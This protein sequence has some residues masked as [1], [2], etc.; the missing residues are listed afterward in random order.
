MKK[1][2]IFVFLSRMS[3]AVNLLPY[4]SVLRTN[5]YICRYI[6]IY[7]LIHI[8]IDILIRNNH[9]QRFRPPTDSPL[10]HYYNSNERFVNLLAIPYAIATSVALSLH[11]N[12]AEDRASEES[13]ILWRFAAHL[14]FCT[15]PLH[16]MRRAGQNDRPPIDSTSVVLVFLSLLLLLT[17]P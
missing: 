9:A 13:N 2:Q 12:I 10:I 14:A 4:V 11:C 16:Q 5:H 6:Y 15:K 7:I 1:K 17:L 8:E 3:P